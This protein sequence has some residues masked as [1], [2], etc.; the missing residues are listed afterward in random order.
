[1]PGVGVSPPATC[2]NRRKA[3]ASS[4]VT[5][6]CTAAED[7][8]RLATVTLMTVGVG[9]TTVTTASDGV[10]GASA[11]ATAATG[12][13]SATPPV[14]EVLRHGEYGLLVP[15]FDV[16]AWADTVVA[17]AAEPERYRAL[18]KAAR[19]CTCC[20]ASRRKATTS[21]SSWI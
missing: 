10:C 5:A 3:S 17:A 20:S 21:F 8:E 15:F 13:E 18:R 2:P 12:P 14:E 6:A 11:A 9:A 1:M 16:E 7:G 4:A 19:Q